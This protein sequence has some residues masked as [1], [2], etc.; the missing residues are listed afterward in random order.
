MRRPLPAAQRCREARIGA[1]RRPRRGQPGRRC[2]QSRPIVAPQTPTRSTSCRRPAGNDSRLRG[3]SCFFCPPAMR[4]CCCGVRTT[5]GPSRTFTQRRAG[6]K[7]A[8]IAC[9][10]I[11]TFDRRRLGRGRPLAL[12]TCKETCRR[13]RRGSRRKRCR[14]W[15][16]R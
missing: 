1:H 12:T 11:W 4:R 2:R 10:T 16:G 13:T 5:R 7:I 14:I 3:P 8:D 6:P 15:A 9:C